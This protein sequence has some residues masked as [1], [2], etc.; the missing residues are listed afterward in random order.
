[1]LFRS[2]PVIGFRL[3]IYPVYFLTIFLIIIVGE[4]DLKKWITIPLLSLLLVVTLY[5]INILRM[6]Y[7][8]VQSITLERMAILADYKIYS[9]QYE[10][11]IWLPR[12]PIYTIHGGDIEVGDVYHMNA[13]KIYFD[14]PQD[15]EIIF[16]WKE[17]Y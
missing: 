1:M 15:E 13:F 3:M 6:K 7:N 14:I 4:M 8:A 2:S 16:Y 12:Y 5:N 11:G 9:D 10:T 17:Q